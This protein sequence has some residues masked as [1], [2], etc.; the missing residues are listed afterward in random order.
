MV[1]VPAA[2]EM[3]AAA[4]LRFGGLT[5]AEHVLLNA[6]VDGHVPAVGRDV[7][8]LRYRADTARTVRGEL[9]RWVFT[10]P[11]VL[12]ALDPGGF[13]LRGARVA[14]PI[15]LA[16]MDVPVRLSFVRC[17][18]DGPLMISD[19]RMPTLNLEGSV[20]RRI[21]GDG[22]RMA[23]TMNLSK[24]RA[25]GRV[26]FVAAT[27]DGDLRLAGATI[28]VGH[29]VA[30][31]LEGLRARYV[32][33]GSGFQ[34]TGG[35]SLVGAEIDGSLSC[36]DARLIAPAAVAR[37][38]EPVGEVRGG[39][40]VDA[41]ALVAAGARIKG[42][43]FI[44][45]PGFRA[46]GLVNLRNARIDG[47]VDASE[48]SFVSATPMASRKHTALSLES[49]HVGGGVNLRCTYARGPVDLRSVET[50]SID[51]SDAVFMSPGEDALLV[52][53]G[54]MKE[55]DLSYA[56]VNGGVSLVRSVVDGAI[57][58][59]GAEL[60]GGPYG[61]LIADRTQADSVLLRRNPSEPSSPPFYAHGRVSVVGAH[62]SGDVDCLGAVFDGEV[63]ATRA[64][65][66]GT[67]RWRPSADSIAQR[68][69]FTDASVGVLDDRDAPWDSFESV[70]LDGLVYRSLTS[71]PSVD[72]ERKTWL[73][74]RL[75]L[76]GR[77]VSSRGLD[78]SQP[79]SGI[80]QP[81]E[82]LAVALRADGYELESRRVGYR[83]EEARRAGLRGWPWL[84]NQVLRVTIGHGYYPR[85]VLYC[86]LALFVTGCLVF[87]WARHANVLI[88]IRQRN[89][90]PEIWAPVYSLDTLLPIVD[91]GQEK[92]WRLVSDGYICGALVQA[93][94]VV[95]ILTGWLLATLGIAAV[96][97]L[98]RRD[99]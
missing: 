15:N 93:Y 81:Y 85:R 34:A 35:V 99:R 79:G 52:D 56:K 8:A 73:A 97:G 69:T 19:A 92:R 31:Q 61:A 22:L 55:L 13:G 66:D 27:I 3:F 68:V 63:D 21:L 37:T 72:A 75:V 59:E 12:E 91:L 9:V 71:V 87:L 45:G 24:L 49:S 47:F 18:L 29:G 23:G 54:R 96:S 86:A 74:E 26:S 80:P 60:R 11:S 7:A 82:Q 40:A 41:S 70:A 51:A 95:H 78:A 14:G 44:R 16:G 43:V 50:R 1:A 94:L 33:L 65:V 6:A 67:L 77:S 25:V 98:L 4:Q 62:I 28:E 2:P 83:R 39:I 36:E 20:S 46:R 48:A 53:G 57:D 76:L 30:L 64:V 84:A 32:L 38:G 90:A 58:C 89:A 10:E 5:S 88:P 42:R 17:A